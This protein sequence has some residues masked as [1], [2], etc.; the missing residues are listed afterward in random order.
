LAPAA[1]EDE[2]RNAGDQLRQIGI[3]DGPEWLCACFLVCCLQISSDAQFILDTLIHDDVCIDRHDNPEDQCRNT[4]ECKHT[5]DRVESEY[6]Q[7]DI[8][9]ECYC[10]HKA[11]QA[12]ESDHEC[13]HKC[14]ADQSGCHRF[15]QCLFTDLGTDRVGIDFIQFHRQGAGV[16]EG[17]DILSPLKPLFTGEAARYHDFFGIDRFGHTWCRDEF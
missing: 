4:G 12:V 7:I 17:R 9:S 16:Q 8:D 15:F 14:H 3:D 5:A 13:E 6:R 10:S 2:Q 1:A 11:G